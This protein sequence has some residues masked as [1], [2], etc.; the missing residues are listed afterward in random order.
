MWDGI[1][2]Y[3]SCAK[4]VLINSYPKRHDSNVQRM[5][6]LP[7]AVSCWSK[8]P[9]RMPLLRLKVVSSIKNN[10]KSNNNKIDLYF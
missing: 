5:P 1:L 4:A 10:Q 9:R 3:N 2:F 8:K 6:I 7:Q